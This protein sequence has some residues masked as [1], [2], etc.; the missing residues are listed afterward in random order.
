MVMVSTWKA[1]GFEGS[2]AGYVPLCG[3]YFMGDPFFSRWPAKLDSATDRAHAPPSIAF[4]MWQAL[5]R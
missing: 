1:P 2:G 5:F 4:G 3:V